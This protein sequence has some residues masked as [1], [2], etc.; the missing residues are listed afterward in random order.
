VSVLRPDRPLIVIGVP[1]YGM[2]APELLEDWMRWAFHLGRRMPAYDFQIA[3]VTKK[4]QFRARNDIVEEARRMDAAYLLMIDDDMIIN[5]WQTFGSLEGGDSAYGF[6]EKL[7]AA[8]KDICGVLYYQRQAGCH[9][10][11]MQGHPDHKGYRFLRDDEI[12]HRLQD[13]DVAGGGCLLIKARVF[14]RLPM[15]FFKPEYDYGT[16]VQLCR[17]AKELGFTVAADTSIELGHLKDERTIIT[18]RN[19]SLHALT[20]SV[21]GEV[22]KAFD[23]EGLY[24]DLLTDACAYTGFSGIEEMSERGQAFMTALNRREAGGSD[25]EWY[26]R[27]GMDRIARQVWFNTLS[28][29]K[30]AMTE[31]LLG[32]IN[33]G[34][35]LRVLDF[36]CGIGIPAFHLAA[37]G[38]KVTAIDLAGTETLAFLRHRVAQHGVR[39]DI[40]ESEGGLPV[41]GVDDEFDIIVAMDAIEHVAQW[42]ALVPLLARHLV[43]GGILFANNSIL[44]DE[45]HPEHYPINGTDFV[46]VCLEAGLLPVNQ[47][48]YEKR[49]PAIRRAAPTDKEPARAEVAYS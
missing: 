38:H 32:V 16:D 17:A 14:N 34:V 35:E 41:L 48:T 4:E 3:I 44:D 12:T 7:L 2:V 40:R 9:A 30:R 42:R 39:M 20:D 18:S 28:P 21:P 49:T 15:P 25:A 13:V 45:H 27:Y 29:H 26:T 33:H 8:D 47:I 5:S 37:R 24:A 6:I 36:G 22:K 43:G 31:G 23:S 10:V 11:L 19:R 1:C 46:Q